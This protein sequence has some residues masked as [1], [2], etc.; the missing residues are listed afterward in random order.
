MK[1]ITVACSC[2]CTC[3][4]TLQRPR[5][6]GRPPVILHIVIITLGV[7][8]FLVPV[9]VSRMRRVRR[10]PA[11][12]RRELDVERQRVARR[13]LLAAERGVLAAELAAGPSR[14]PG[15]PRCGFPIPPRT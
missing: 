10:P 4:C 5:Q 13:R 8:V 11:E 7:L 12:R 9:V 3:I 6:H 14:R 1:I 15:C 2:R